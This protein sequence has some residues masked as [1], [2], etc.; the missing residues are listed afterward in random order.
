MAWM[1]SSIVGKPDAKDNVHP[2]KERPENRI[3]GPAA[4]L[5]ALGRTLPKDNAPSPT[6]GGGLRGSCSCDRCRR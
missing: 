1:L 6:S 2:R 5:M 3:E 4:L